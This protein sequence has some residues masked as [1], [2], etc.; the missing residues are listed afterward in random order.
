MYVATLACLLYYSGYA[1][2][3]VGLWNLFKSLSHHTFF[4]LRTQQLAYPYMIQLAS[5]LYH[6]YR[7]SGCGVVVDSLWPFE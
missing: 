6:S 1:C 2:F 7:A 3:V 4:T 5:L